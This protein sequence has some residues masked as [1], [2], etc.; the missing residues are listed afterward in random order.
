[1]GVGNGCL[2]RTQK[3]AAALGSGCSYGHT[4][5]A[6]F[7]LMMTRRQILKILV[8]SGPSDRRELL[9]I[10]DRASI[11]VAVPS[12]DGTKDAISLK[13]NG[14][15]V[16]GTERGLVVFKFT[17]R[18]ELSGVVVWNQGLENDHSG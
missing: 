15:E 5:G 4:G 10:F 14:S 18:G 17:K 11:D 9:D 12:E 7:N 6:A 13:V 1:M 3:Q 2:N 8:S 16:T